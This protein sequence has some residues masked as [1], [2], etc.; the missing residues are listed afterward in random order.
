MLCQLGLHRS[1]CIPCYPDL[2]LKLSCQHHMADTGYWRSSYLDSCFKILVAL[3]DLASFFLNVDMLLDFSF[4][5]LSSLA[6][7]QNVKTC[8]LICLILISLLFMILFQVWFRKTWD[9]WPLQAHRLQWAVNTEHTV[10]GQQGQ[11]IVYLLQSQA[12]FFHWK[13][14]HIFLFLLSVC[15]WKEQF[16]H[17]FVLRSLV[18]NMD[19]LLFVIS[20]LSEKLPALCQYQ[21]MYLQENFLDWF[22]SNFMRCLYSEAR[23]VKLFLPQKISCS[24][25]DE[26]CVCVCVSSWVGMD[27]VGVY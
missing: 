19:L 12:I 22:L 14:F 2:S 5:P 23:D 4:F 16:E 10:R 11:Q 15:L 13:S 7:T 18:P 6:C 1:H 8:T 27:F 20:R 3:D 21:N 17:I 24:R 26:M 9:C 25:V